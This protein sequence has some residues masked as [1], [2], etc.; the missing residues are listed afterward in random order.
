[1][2]DQHAIADL[3]SRI[4]YPEINHIRFGDLFEVLGKGF[5]DFRE[6]PS[7]MVFLCIFYP[8]IGLMLV[9]LTFGYDILPLLFPLV[10]GFA[11][12]GPLAALGLYEISRRK[13]AGE[14]VSWRHAF[15]VFYA[16]SIWSIVILGGF[17]MAIFFAWLLTADLIYSS[18][19]GT[20][21]AKSGGEFIHKVF[22]SPEGMQLI[23][24]G[25]SAGFLFAFFVFLISAVSFPM[26]LDRNVSTLT[27]VIT[28]IRAVYH[29]PITML[30]WG[31]IIAVSLF[32]GAVPLFIGLVV[33]MPILGHATWHL[34]RK[35]VRN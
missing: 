20:Y 7:H 14:D 33:I 25:N 22:N 19:F 34:Y 29:N 8:I 2:A 27:A 9:R 30:G 35:V 32:A 28:S 4:E 11:L 16:P 5:D 23:I 6:N 15:N 1:M 17:L 12:I 18:L 3:Q 31:L 24:L 10:A 13:E 21:Q 26:L